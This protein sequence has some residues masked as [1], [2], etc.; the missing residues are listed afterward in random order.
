MAPSQVELY[1]D[2]E[3][4]PCLSVGGS[5]AS[6]TFSM[7]RNSASPTDPTVQPL[8][9]VSLT[10]DQLTEIVRVLVA[11]ETTTTFGLPANFAVVGNLYYDI[12]TAGGT[13]PAT[14]VNVCFD[15]SD[16]PNPSDLWIGHASD[17][18]FEFQILSTT[19]DTVNHRVCAVADGFS[20]FTV[21]AFSDCGDGIVQYGEECDD[22][23]TVD[24][25]CCANACTANQQA[26]EDDGDLCTEDVCGAGVCTHVVPTVTCDQAT[27]LR[28]SLTLKKITDPTKS[29]AIWKWQ[30]D[31]IDLGGLGA[32][33]GGHDLGICI[34]DG[35]GIVM[36]ARVP[37]FGD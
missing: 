22:G 10:F 4:S 20:H 24:D 34:Y 12:H 31:A 5:F 27:S 15:Y 14:A 28:S 33:D 3:V 11:P 29:K 7:R 19:L 30:G 1:N 9:N 16:V 23:N 25:D 35:D 8:P 13:F 36:S 32:P 17:D 26:C 2:G 21:L 37:A 18:D 6:C